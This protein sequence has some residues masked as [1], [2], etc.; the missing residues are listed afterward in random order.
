MLLGIKQF[1]KNVD[2]SKIIHIIHVGREILKIRQQNIPLI[3]C[4]TLYY[5]VLL[6]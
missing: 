6:Y 3:H 2:I 4:K 5:I 1:F